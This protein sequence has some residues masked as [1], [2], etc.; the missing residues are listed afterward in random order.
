[1]RKPSILKF[2]LTTN[3]KVIRLTHII[4]NYDSQSS[5]DC[6]SSCAL[7]YV[8]IYIYIYLDI[9]YMYN[10]QII[11]YFVTYE[12]SDVT[13]STMCMN[14]IYNNWIAVILFLSL[15]L[16]PAY[17]KSSLTKKGNTN[18][19]KLYNTKKTFLLS[20]YL[21]LFKKR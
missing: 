4:Y 14:I 6:I 12:I 21:K 9:F 11:Y 20:F 16:T 17:Y 5:E 19:N 2:F 8:H 7:H 15:G 13:I 18:S 1:M 3:I 10:I